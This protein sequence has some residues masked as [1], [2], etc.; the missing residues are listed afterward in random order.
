MRPAR[1]HRQDQ[2]LGVGPD[3][4]RLAGEPFSRPLAI[5]P[6]RTGHVTGLRAVTRTAVA[7]RVARH[8]IAAVEHFDRARRGAAS[9]CSRI[10]AC[11]TEY[12][13]PAT[14]TW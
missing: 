8:P 7:P 2:R 14:S 12:K 1:Q 9:T 3:V 11:G 10:S 4:T 5:A 6:V 13:K